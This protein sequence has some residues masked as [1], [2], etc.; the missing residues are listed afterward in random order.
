MKAILMHGG[1]WPL[2]E[3][4]EELRK[5]D[6]PDI[7]TFC[8]HKGTSAM[9]EALQ[10]LICKDVKYG[11]S[12]LIPILCVTSIPGLC[13]APMY[14]MA[15]NMLDELGTILPKNRLTH[16]QS[17][18]WSSGTSVISCVQK[19]LLQACRYRFYI[20]HLV[21][22]AVATRRIYPNQHTLASKINYKLAYQQGT[23][24][25]K[26]ALLPATSSHLVLHL[27]VLL[28]LWNGKFYQ[29]QFAIQQTSCSNAKIGI[30]T[31]YMHQYKKRSQHKNIWKMTYLL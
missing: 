11:Y 1:V 20:R 3:L 24:H 14:I 7:L 9:P 18:K 31:H 22:W 30:Q 23:L 10:K 17:W 25:F 8:K 21:N 27:V 28:S 15:Q 12:I 4:E 29:K 5:H 16:G 19:E 26:T 2:V 6:L 13:M